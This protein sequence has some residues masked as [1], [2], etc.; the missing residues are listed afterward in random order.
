MK[1]TAAD[2]AEWLGRKDTRIWRASGWHDS[3]PWGATSSRLREVAC[4]ARTKLT[5]INAAIRAERK[6]KKGKG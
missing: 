3:P 1:I 2:R 5:A 6:A 4:F